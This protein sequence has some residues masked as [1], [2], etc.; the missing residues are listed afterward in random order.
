MEA[1]TL[2]TLCW[3]ACVRVNSQLLKKGT[4]GEGTLYGP[5]YLVYVGQWLLILDKHLGKLQALIRIY[6]HHVSQEENPVR[7]IAHLQKSNW[8]KMLLIVQ[9][10]FS[11]LVIFSELN[12]HI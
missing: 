6:T 1:P 12:K 3:S 2:G 11:Y 10:Y 8:I 9:T 7:S 5:T 4:C